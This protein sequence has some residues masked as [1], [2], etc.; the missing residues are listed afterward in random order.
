MSAQ[1]SINGMIGTIGSAIVAGK[2]LSNQSKMAD[3]AQIEKD[4]AAEEAK[5]QASY[6]EELNKILGEET[7]NN[8]KFKDPE[9]FNKA[10][11]M[12]EGKKAMML[13][14]REAVRTYRN[15]FSKGS[16]EYNMI[17]SEGQ[18]RKE[19]NFQEFRKSLRK[20]RKGGKSNG[21]NK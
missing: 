20:L 4:K 12:M 17:E 14:Q 13:A 2:A 16:E 3:A 19:A 15:Q 21:R 7:L 6:G 1:S 8:A 18:A 10:L 5:K 9:M 11:D